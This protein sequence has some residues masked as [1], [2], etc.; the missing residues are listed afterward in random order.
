M[1]EKD[2]KIKDKNYGIHN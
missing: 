2:I 1:V